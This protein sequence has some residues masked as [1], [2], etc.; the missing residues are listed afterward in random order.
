MKTE[1][2][3][4]ERLNRSQMVAVASLLDQI[5]TRE[6]LVQAFT[7]FG[8]TELIKWGK[9]LGYLKKTRNTF[10]FTMPFEKIAAQQIDLP[11]LID[12]LC[13]VWENWQKS[14]D[15]FEWFCERIRTLR[16]LPEDT[17]VIF[18]NQMG[19]CAE[20]HHCPSLAVTIYIEAFMRAQNLLDMGARKTLMVRSILNIS[21]I[22]FMRGISP[23]QTLKRQHETLQLINQG[24][25]TAED[26]LL[27]L[28]TG[29]SEHFCGSIREGRR[30]RET[31][32]KYL[33]QFDYTNI[34]A[35]VTPLVGWHYYLRG[36]FTETIAYYESLILAIESREDL[37]IVAFAYPPI[38]FSYIFLGEYYKALILAEKLHRSALKSQDHYA[39][40]LML[41]NIGRTYV[42]MDDLEK[43]ET[44]LYQAYA[45]AL[46]Q[47]Y[48]WGL[49]YTLLGI[50]YLQYKK[51]NNY[52]CREHF[53]LALKAA[54]QHGFNPISA[55]PFTFDVLK[56]VDD[57][58]LE[59]IKGISFQAE[60]QNT[61][62]SQNLHMTGVAYRF[63]AIQSIDEGRSPEEVIRNLHASIQRLEVSGSRS[64]L[65]QTYLT[66]AHYCRGLSRENDARKFAQ[67]AWSCQ[68]DQEHKIFP[69]DLMGY[70]VN[71]H[72]EVSLAT[73]LETLWL[74]LRHIINP[75]RLTARLLTSVCRQLQAEIGVF[76]VKRGKKADIILA[77]NFDRD[78]QSPQY[79]RMV[80]IVAYMEQNAGIFATQNAERAVQEELDLKQCPRFCVCIPFYNGEKAEI[81]LFLESYYR[82]DPLSQEEKT[83]LEKFAK[84]ISPHLF[85]AMEYHHTSR[86]KVQ[87]EAANHGDASPA[88][89]GDYC[90]SVDEGVLLLQTQID[91]VA[92]ISVPIL[93]TGETGVG[94]EVFCQEIYRK[95]GCTGPYVKVN[96]GAIP[97]SLLESE[98]FGYERGSFTGATSQKKGYFELADGGTLFLDEIGELTLQAQIKLLRV[99]QEHE[100]IRIGG[101]KPI[102]VDFR[103]IAA[104]NKE[105]HKEVERGAFRKDLYYRLNVIQFVI[106]PLRERK[107]DIINM[108]RFFAN[109]FCKQ[110]DQPYCRFSDEAV[111]RMMHYNWPGNVRELENMVQRAVLLAEGNIITDEMLFQQVETTT[112]SPHEKLLCLDEVERRYITKVLRAC[113]GRIGGPN[114]AAAILGIKR[115]TLNSKMARLGLRNPVLSHGESE[116]SEVG[117]EF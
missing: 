61:L 43:A 73:L 102:Q 82:E 76:I 47:D 15:M 78:P 105:L 35:E 32:I 21:R 72:V 53:A 6:Q 17:C 42:Y 23:R 116:V 90:P 93:I 97:E 101:T 65:A 98:L 29:M 44:I 96:C 4:K 86:L 34:E 68:S 80:A 3:L 112:E 69:R 114:G 46:Q 56:M 10:R 50:A 94:K 111:T 41:S 45:E 25:L 103:L 113:G 77:Q 12:P 108:A 62:I 5:W 57:D 64:Q 85:A 81:M 66:Y 7:E 11:V 115:T 8:A 52:A 27:M 51:R 1:T 79:Q 26:A 84:K 99:L 13:C 58:G 37:A 71:D 70:V 106:P 104:T 100:F 48:G 24:N 75:D 60:L 67:L 33:E 2:L 59:P 16:D 40:I 91:K 87:T 36:N 54:Q 49:Y 110:I 88:G 19:A 39:A 14:D 117:E 63:R 83:L 55:S 30:L 18:F 9:E 38:I 109:R 31:A 89:Q 28:Y 22:E 74:E 107:A 95:S 92:K 20:K